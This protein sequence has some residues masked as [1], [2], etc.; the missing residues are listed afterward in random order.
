[1]VDCLDPQAEPVQLALLCLRPH[2][3]GGVVIQGH[4]MMAHRVLLL[5][6]LNETVV[7][8][9]LLCVVPLEVLNLL[10]GLSYLCLEDGRIVDKVALKTLF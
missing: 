3:I 2:M 6:V 10:V 8:D 9:L 4:P 7:F 1:M 5:H